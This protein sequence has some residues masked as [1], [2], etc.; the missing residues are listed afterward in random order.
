MSAPCNGCPFK[1]VT[2]CGIDFSLV[3]KSDHEDFLTGI[4]RLI[5]GGRFGCHKMLVRF[6]GDGLTWRPCIGALEWQDK[7]GIDRDPNKFQGQHELDK[8][9]KK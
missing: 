2:S 1:G 5:N 8:Q 3:A 6:G 4:R 9:F 7:H